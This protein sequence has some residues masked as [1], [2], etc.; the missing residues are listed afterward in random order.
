MEEL[1]RA[2]QGRYADV[3]IVTPVTIYQTVLT[4]GPTYLWFSRVNFIDS[5]VKELQS[6]GY[7]VRAQHLNYNLY[8]VMAM[9]MV[10]A[11]AAGWGM[12]FLKKGIEPWPIAAT[13]LLTVVGALLFL[14]RR[15]ERVAHMAAKLVEMNMP[16]D[17]MGMTLYQMGEIYARRYQAPS[18]VET[19]WTWDYV[20]KYAF[21]W[22]YY[23][24]FGLY[25]LSF[26]DTV[27]WTLAGCVLAVCVYQL[28]FLLRKG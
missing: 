7:P 12:I 24:A 2:D 13:G 22:T 14:M 9:I 11:S 16:R 21:L 5:V 26:R 15:R 25:F 6:A 19:V 4:D 20:L 27:I 1:K 18:L 28:Y 17:P 10:A 23:G 3:R 8:S